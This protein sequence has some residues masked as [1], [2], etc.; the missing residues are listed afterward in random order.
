MKILLI[1]ASSYVGAR[2]YFDLKDSYEVVGTYNNNLL[3]KS[4]V[5]LDITDSHDV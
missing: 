5:K 1:G 3:S 4:F 2:I